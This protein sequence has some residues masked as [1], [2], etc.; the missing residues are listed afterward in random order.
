MRLAL[1]LQ[2]HPGGRPPEGEQQLAVG[3]PDHRRKR[4]IEFR[5]FVNDQVAN[6]AN[7]GAEIGRVAG[8]QGAEHQSGNEYQSGAER[9][10]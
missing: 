3:P 1:L 4:R 5:V 8:G 9:G 2:R 6:L 10:A 7:A